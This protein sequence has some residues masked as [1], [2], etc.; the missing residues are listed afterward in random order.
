MKKLFAM[1]GAGLSMFSA[2]A[3]DLY[4]FADQSREHVFL[5]CFTCSPYSMDSIWN[6]YGKYGSKYSTQSIWNAYGNFGSEYS[7]Y[8]PWNRYANRAP[9]LVDKQGNFYGYFTCNPHAPKRV[10]KDLMD[11]ICNNLESIREDRKEFYDKHF[12]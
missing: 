2:H 6:N 3:K 8:S 10:K 11:F 1:L 7:N 9:V 4:L 5:G 12:R